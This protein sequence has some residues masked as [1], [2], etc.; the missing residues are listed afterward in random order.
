MVL[1]LDPRIPLVWR[2]PDVVQLGVERPLAVVT[3]ASTADERML[4]A[5]AGGVTRAGLSMIGTNAGATEAEV[6][7]LFTSIRPALLPRES[8]PAAPSPRIVIDGSGR[9]AEHLAAML[10]ASGCAVNGDA[11]PGSVDLAIDSA[12]LA[13]V[14]AHYA[15]APERYGIWLRRDIPHLAIVFGDRGVRIGPLVEPGTGPCLYCVELTRTDDDPDW[16]A[17]AAQLYTRT[18]PAETP[19]T[20]AEVASLAARAILARV[21]GG[22]AIDGYAARSI[23]IDN[24]TGATTVR[25]HRPHVDCGCQA[26][27]GNVMELVSRHAAGRSPTNSGEGVVVRA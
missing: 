22:T 18:A 11:E 6:T 3:D 5:L 24:E 23:R 1:R 17:M 15:I 21:G 13:V 25:E 8:G 12:D 10:R 20:S 14:F 26:L 9:T 2:S 19:I 27:P 4:E 16:P 7:R